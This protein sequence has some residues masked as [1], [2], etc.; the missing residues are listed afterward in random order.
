MFDSVRNNKKVVQGILALIILPFAFW[1]VDSFFRNSGGGSDSVA[2]VAGSKISLN[3]FQQALRE[4]QDKLRP[5]LAGRDPALLDSPELRRAVL[6][7]LVQRRLLGVY[8]SKSK[9]FVSNEQLASFISSVPQLQEDG[10]FS[11]QRYDALIAAQGKSKEAFEYEV[12][13]DMTIQQAVA[14]VGNASL[15]GNTAAERW[16]AAQLE[17]REVSE[18]VLRPDPFLGQVKL[19]PEV[20]QAYYDANLKKFELPEQLRAEY[21]VLS[22]DH[23]GDQVAVSDAEIKDWYASHADRYKQ[24][25]ERRAS[26]ILINL[27]AK[28]S[29]DEVK[30]A[31]AKAAGLLAQVKKNP[32]DFARLAKVNS[33]DPGS[34]ANGGDLDWFGRGAMVKAFEDA[35]FSLKEGQISD[36]VRSD[37]GLHIIK[38]TGIRPERTRPLE[39]V[40]GEITAELKAQTAA[41]KYAEI[42]EGFS[43]TVYEQPDSLAPA[44]EKYKLTVQTSD[45]L[46][47]GG[48]GAGPLSN[49][50][51]MAALFSDDAIKNKRNT[52]AIEVAPNVLVSARVVDHK[53]VV[54]QALATVAP[55]ISK[56]L[57]HEEAVKLAV[58]D[59]EQKLAALGKGTKVDLSWSK[60]HAVTR[61]MSGGVP[62]D[63][64]R[65]IFGAEAG[66]L[67]AY[68]GVAG[69]GGY[70][71]F[72]ISQVKP[73][74][75]GTGETPQAHALRGEY[76]RLVAEEEMA[77]WIASLKA[78]YPVEINQALLTN[79]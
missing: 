33:Q 42:A 38:L 53:P 29:D 12:R 48:A 6:D 26:H 41:K 66:K 59:G 20:V 67:P 40:R 7:D 35:A 16:L 23:L 56:L 28:A 8:A 71:L 22:R 63:A 58:K 13:H 18:A 77:A 10:K 78:K 54:Q 17:E 57:T 47:K 55:T 44:A 4:Q 45:W 60:P 52:E 5:M 11:P 31:E 39:E 15:A 73:F 14:A 34:A 9:L 65:A 25:E 70:I 50:K 49:A 75:A 76:A 1:G 69:A 2:S 61:A 46:T 68:S 19:A 21:L 51:L 37:F 3:E 24:A 64:V 36:V 74:T 30:A 79:K 27:A 72:R 43:N 32:G 62:P